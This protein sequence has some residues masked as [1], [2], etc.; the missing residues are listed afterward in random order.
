MKNILFLLFFLTLCFCAFAQTDKVKGTIA[1]TD[2]ADLTILNIYPDSFPDVSVVFKAE[3]RKGE[4]VWNLTKEKMIVK[5]NGQNCEVVSLEQVS[6]NKAINLGIVV[7]HSG[8]MLLDFAQLIDSTGKFLFEKNP[9]N[10]IPKG[11]VTPLDNAKTA[12]K[13]FVSTFNKEKDFVS[14]IGFS[15][16]IDTKLPLT[17]DTSKISVAVDSMHA[18]FSTALYDAMISGID[19]IKNAEGVKVLVTLTDGQDNMSK[20]TWKDVVDKANKEEIPIYII[21]LGDANA[22][23]LNLIATSTKGQFYYTRSSNSLN[24]I[25]AAISKKVQAFYDIIYHSPNFSSADSTRQIE[26]TFTTDSMVLVTNPSTA[27]FPV[28]VVTLIAN[29]EKEKQFLLYGGGIAVIVLVAA[30]TLLFY[31]KR[32]TP[33]QNKKMPPVITKIFPNPSA[34]KINLEY[35]GGSGQLQIFN[36]YG[37]VSRTIPISGMETQFDLTGLTPGNYFAVIKTAAE[38]SNTVAFV[39]QR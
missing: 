10:V 13:A 39:I 16:T 8:S 35:T 37:Q 6:K 15:N 3:T 17:N 26:L 19:Q 18:D 14:I 25:Y 23:T 31:R 36:L 30:S 21:G 1:T 11:Y 7:D 29:K 32:K 28:E 33:A 27:N 24:T 4:P 2:T 20:A 38:Q 12:V 9:D 5:E 34:G 22:D